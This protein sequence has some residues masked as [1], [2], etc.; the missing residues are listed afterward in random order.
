MA[1]FHKA[2][3]MGVV[4][5]ETDVHFTRDRRL[6]LQHDHTLD[7]NTSGAGA[8]GDFDLAT[9]KEL[10]AGSWAD[11]A[12]HPGLMWDRDYSGERLI[13]LDELFTEFGERFLY[14]VELKDPD[15]A[16]AGAVGQAIDDSGFAE[17]CFVTGF[18]RPDDLIRVKQQVPGVRTCPLIPPRCDAA[19]AIVDT[20]AQSHDA[21]SLGARVVTQDLVTAGHAAGLEV[22][23]WGVG[24]RD[25]MVAAASC[26]SNGM[27]INWPDWLLDWV[28]QQG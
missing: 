9:L 16:I 24:N 5:V 27:T 15:P 6:L 28:A 10:D 25:D 4:E 26:G 20:A 7:R 12:Q 2:L 21:I 14:H 1:A 19:Q 13:T 11:P 17:R 8:P 18:E 23:C 22:R 3:S